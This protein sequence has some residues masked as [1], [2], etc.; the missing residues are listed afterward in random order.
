MV[1]HIA[2][3]LAF[4][5]QQR[6]SIVVIANHWLPSVVVYHSGQTHSNALPDTKPTLS[7]LDIARIWV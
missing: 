7:A 3:L 1:A 2:A 5:P 6:Y 4:C